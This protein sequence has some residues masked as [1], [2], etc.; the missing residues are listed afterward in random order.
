MDCLMCGACCENFGTIEVRSEDQI[1][2]CLTYG[3]FGGF[4]GMRTVRGRCVCL[5]TVNKCK[6]Y[7]RRPVTCRAF[8]PGGP[9]CLEA[10]ELRRRGR[11]ADPIAEIG[12]AIENSSRS[13]LEAAGAGRFMAAVWWVGKDGDLRY[14]R[15]SFDFPT[16]RFGESIAMM[17][18]DLEEAAD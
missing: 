12:D 6:E 10:R 5:S 4:R 8:E 1:P 16:A 2:D 13:L 18:G 3:D 14:S 17:Q 11:K 15:T 9:K 7:E